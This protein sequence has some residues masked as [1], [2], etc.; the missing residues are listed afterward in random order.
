MPRSLLLSRYLP[1]AVVSMML[2]INAGCMHIADNHKNSEEWARVQARLFD[3]PIPLN[4][5]PLVLPVQD[6]NQQVLRYQTA[7]P[8]NEL[9]AFCQQEMEMN[10]WYH[11]CTI[12]GM[13]TLL[14][15]SKPH[16]SCSMVIREDK[17]NRLVVTVFYAAK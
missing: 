7:L 8:L 9:I 10:G 16:A 5:I 11:D 4:T 15:F 17:K 13:E 6:D 1:T 12:H 2:L 14:N 3:V